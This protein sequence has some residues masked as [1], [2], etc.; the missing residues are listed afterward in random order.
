MTD[1]PIWPG[2]T[3]PLNQAASPAA[4]VTDGTWRLP[5][6]LSPRCSN[7][8]C[9]PIAGM[10]RETGAERARDGPWPVALVTPAAEADGWGA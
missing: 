5:S 4:V 2:V 6:W 10:S 9:T 3:D 8:E 1:E 7:R